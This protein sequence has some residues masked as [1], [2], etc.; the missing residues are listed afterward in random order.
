MTTIEKLPDGGVEVTFN[1]EEAYAMKVEE[2]RN[3][4]WDH[5][6]FLT[7][8]HDQRKKGISTY[9]IAKKLGIKGVHFRISERHLE[10]KHRENLLNLIV[11][12]PLTETYLWHIGYG[13]DNE[14]IKQQGFK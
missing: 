8:I 13:E 2:Y 6:G 10:L 12:R 3:K 4:K 5:D 9:R 1:S 11:R 14:T 7:F